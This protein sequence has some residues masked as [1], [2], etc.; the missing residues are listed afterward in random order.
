ML[1][2][3]ST[4]TMLLGVFGVMLKKM[5][6]QSSRALWG[7]LPMTVYAFQGFV[8]VPQTEVEHELVCEKLD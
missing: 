4:V 3:V 6:T 7:I 8:E 2:G 1:S 5:E